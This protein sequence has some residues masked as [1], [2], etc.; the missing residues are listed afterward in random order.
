MTVI[1]FSGCR[2][3]VDEAEQ[4]AR[5]SELLTSDEKIW[6]SEHPEITLGIG[7]TWEPFVY[8]KNDGSLEGFDVDMIDR[9]NE[10]TGT[11]IELVA[12]PWAEIVDMAKKVEI[13]GLAVS[14]V[15]PERAGNF[16]F[17]DPYNET[18]FG[19]FTTPERA[20]KV[21]GPESFSGKR[22]TQLKGNLFVRNILLSMDKIEII[23][24]D[25]EYEAFRLVLE[26]KADYAIF[27]LFQFAPLQSVFHQSIVVAHVFDTEQ[28]ALKLVYS[29]RKDWPELI[30]ILN[31][32]LS[33]VG[34]LERQQILSSWV[35]PVMVMTSSAMELPDSEYPGENMFNTSMFLIRI[36]GAFSALLL[37]ILFIIWQIKGRPK[38][39]TIKDL[40]ILLS[41][42]FAVLITASSYLVILLSRSHEQEDSFYTL[43][44]ESRELALELK[45]SSDDL[46]R[47]ARTYVV[48]GEQ[49]YKD[50]F[51]R[52]VKI[53]NGEEAHPSDYSN[54]S[55]DLIIGGVMVF[56]QDGET[57]SIEERINEL[58]LTKQEILKLSEAKKATDELVYLENTAFNAIK[59][60]Y[61]D[62]AGQFT[63]IAEP[64]S[65]YAQS[66][67][68]GS[69]YHR[70]KAEIMQPIEEFFILIERRMQNE[71]NQYKNRKASIISG[72]SMLVGM[73]VL[74]CI[75]IFIIFRRRIILPLT[76]LKN[77]ASA[78]Q[79]G[80]YSNSID[81]IKNDEIG[82]L[83]S[84]FNLMARSVEER[85]ST[86]QATIES[87]T[88]GILVVDL[89]QRINSYNKQF[90]D[91]WQVDKELADRID[92]S[93]LLKACAAKTS[94]PEEFLNNVEEL[95]KNP[96]V[97]DFATFQLFDGRLLERYSKPQK[98]ADKI[99]GRVW[100]FRD[101]TERYQYEASLNEN[102]QRVREAARIS[103][104]G[105][106]QLNL[107]TMIF[108]FDDLMWAVLGTSID[109]EESDTISV[110]EYLIRFCHSEDQYKI[111]DR[112][113][114]IF[115]KKEVCKDEFGYRVIRP[116]GS[117]Q[118]AYVR[119]HVDYDD[120]GNPFRVYGSHQDITERNKTE[121]ELK[122]SEE[123]LQAIIDNLPS[124]VILK[125]LYSRHLLVNSFYENA[126]GFAAKE[127]LGHTDAE[128]FP[129]DIAEAIMKKDKEVMESGQP[130]TFEWQLPPHPDGTAHTYLTTKVPLSDEQGTVN[131]LV[132]LSTD[133]TGRI[134]GEERLRKNEAQLRTIVE[135]SPIGIIHFN[136]KGLIVNCNSV[137]SEILGAS[138]DRLLGFDAPKKLVNS[139]MAN[140]LGRA[141]NGDNAEF[142]GEYVSVTGEKKVW[143]HIVFNP[144]ISEA[145]KY[146]VICTIEDITKRKQDEVQLMEAK[147][148]AEAATQIKSDF[149]A[150]MSHEI[151]TPMN[152]IVGM[153][154]LVLKTDLTR[155]QRDYINKIDQ[156]SKSLLTIIN[157]ILDFSKIE[158]G[159]LE[160]ESIPFYLDEV[161]DNLAGMISIKCQQKG[162]ELVFNIAPDFPQELIGDPLRTGQI[163]INLSSNAIKFTETGEIVISAD[164]VERMDDGVLAR[165]SVK[166]TGVGLSLEQQERL[167]QSFT[168]ADT[169]TTRKYGG[170]GLGLAIS[171][172]LAELM[173]GEIGVDSVPGSGS[174]FW[175]TAGFGLHNQE[176]ERNINYSVLA[177]NLKGERVLIVDDNENSLQSLSSM[178]KSF[179][180]DVTTASSAPEALDLL[181][182]AAAENHF[183]L[184]LMDMK[185]PGMDG[186]EAT[187]LI[188]SNPRLKDIT[189]VIMI[190]AYGREEFIH[191]AEAVGIES[192][193]VKPVSQSV[194]FNTVMDAFGGELK[195][196]N[197]YQ[198][199]EISLPNN[200]DAIR[201][202]RILLVEDNEFNQQVAI[203][204]LESEGFYVTVADNG[205]L[206]VDAVTEADPVAFDVVL[207]DL[208]MPEMDGFSAAKILRSDSQ[209]DPLPI[210]AMTAD[211]M[212][213]VAEQ[214]LEIGMNDYVTKPIDPA[215]LFSALAK[216]IK[217]DK[218]ILPDGFKSV[219]SETQNGKDDFPEIEGIDVQAGLLLTGGK[220]ERYR[221][222][223]NQFV[224]NQKD[225]AEK[226]R[227]A[228]DSGSD[229]EAV[230]LAH[231]L[232]GVAGTIGA[233]LLQEKS[234][235]LESILKK[236]GGKETEELLKDLEVI[237]NKVITAIQ[238]VLV[239][240][241]VSVEKSE[242]DTVRLRELSVSLRSYLLEDDSKS[243]DVIDEILE[244]VKGSAY[245]NEYKPV[246]NNIT[247]I[248]YEEA[249]EKLNRIINSG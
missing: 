188:K 77:G 14:T 73:T 138:V 183:P 221:K 23:D 2:D 39:L 63:F 176:K 159:K 6:I 121:E 32:A 102:N 148:A 133:I 164:I 222:L 13:D 94:H 58:E 170:T 246:Q 22:I 202:A 169:S 199:S 40:L 7:E 107:Q 106:F 101:V 88:D 46:T 44:L 190:T 65:V 5:F 160:V 134:Q 68:Y 248:E 43:L 113:E 87:T 118:Y 226:F 145:A 52:I 19:L 241:N 79:K 179:G 192:F 233:V 127:L 153:S 70:I 3:K 182:A 1:S 108:T 105:Y 158:A 143:L 119:Y 124:S 41:C 112:I 36:I 34:R 197:S 236:G 140:A 95:H 53:Q 216:W 29:I 175:F 31:K 180:F 165:F 238:T 243:Q 162:L 47:M 50:Y 247:E 98:H 152:A 229:K 196:R 8:V 174:T 132:V 10:I 185:M 28:P 187:Q 117:I 244:L 168:Q 186:L 242:V 203:E 166:D 167:F 231:T 239:E 110:D 128:I 217:P 66:L 97:E 235:S 12:G 78:I 161:L 80:D 240:E 225:T 33:V 198:K 142:D 184:V 45:Q 71:L 131:S 51:D 17:S 122:L 224:V 200:F 137:A 223:L 150:N 245:E 90:L 26:G 38:Q 20:A 25:S 76:R 227:K 84:V 30:A 62:E 75:F 55:W 234:K 208:Q 171:K 18:E 86:L 147:E 116:D 194:L 111:K 37:I 218:R 64:D 54:F 228:M 135:N 136:S 201:G 230:R 59:G 146:E 123:R 49:I 56:N 154:Y 204:L 151:R 129:A 15:S 207:M 141:L 177:E 16:L 126:T 163:L 210:I 191:Q 120:L 125:D 67:L 219:E 82:E 155:K 144:V 74:F 189:T 57:Y 205:R 69:D 48:T 60:I 24:A 4:R 232:K 89:N 212:T 181:E 99:F 149:L 11:N 237:L 156:S 85:T 206:A 81:A 213:G 211:A 109:D 35:P 115:E 42:I 220:P 139:E 249:L 9:I 215:V 92:S 72:I 93:D 195:F 91:I 209:Y 193:M 130:E 96:D 178:I 172:N 61:R 27:A 104:L 173:G 114:E 21:T 83:S 157:D 103:H 214:V 100:S